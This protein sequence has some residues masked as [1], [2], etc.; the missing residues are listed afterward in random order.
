MKYIRNYHNLTQD[1]LAKKL[2]VSRKTISAWENN[3]GIPDYYLVKAIESIFNIPENQLMNKKQKIFLNSNELQSKFKKKVNWALYIEIIFIFLGYLT[4]LKIYNNTINSCILIL[5]SIY[6]NIQLNR[7]SPDNFQKSLHK[8]AVLYLF[9]I[10]LILG[11]SSFGVY[12]FSSTLSN[13]E[14]AA[15]F[16]AW[17]IIS[18]MLA[19]AI[20]ISY[21]SFS[22]IKTGKP[23]AS[24]SEIH[25]FIKFQKNKN[26]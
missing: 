4:L 21:Q 14:F 19:Q 3:R 26:L 12:L 7:F 18:Y 1:Q 23:W 15:A 22:L 2:N 11:N 25:K 10:N 5:T 8:K 9:T 13:I 20:V 16:M 24:F 6:L 17:I